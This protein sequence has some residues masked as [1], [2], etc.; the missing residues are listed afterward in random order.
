VEKEAREE[1]ERSVERLELEVPQ[2]DFLG[3]LDKS[4]N[5]EYTL[6]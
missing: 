5:S 6:H 1:M 2:M 4:T 3:L